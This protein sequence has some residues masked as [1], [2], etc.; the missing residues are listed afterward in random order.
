M[1]L[2]AVMVW[3]REGGQRA[4]RGLSQTACCLGRECGKGRVSIQTG[5]RVP[6]ASRTVGSKM[7]GVVVQ[8]ISTIAERIF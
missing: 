1:A 8:K 2:E 6:V 5:E 4:V 3:M 7:G